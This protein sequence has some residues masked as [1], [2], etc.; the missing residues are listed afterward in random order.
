MNKLNE[1]LKNDSPLIFL[2]GSWVIS[3]LSVFTY[4]IQKDCKVIPPQSFLDGTFL[5]AFFLFFILPFFRTLRLG[6]ILAL[7]RDIQKTKQEIS[8]IYSNMFRLSAT[9]TSTLNINVSGEQGSEQISNEQA[10]PPLAQERKKPRSA[11]DLKILN[12]LWLKQVEKFPNLS[13][14]FTFRM[15]FPPIKPTFDNL[16]QD[17]IYEGLIGKTSK[18]QVFL[19]NLG[20][21]YCAENYQTFPSDTWFDPEPLNQEKLDKIIKAIKNLVQ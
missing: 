1:W 18:N 5:W 12:T 20:L 21:Q 17:L 10:A 15:D 19:T 7:E 8:E 16:A 6:N 2:I 3:I 13:K 9:V 4:F 11:S 14:R